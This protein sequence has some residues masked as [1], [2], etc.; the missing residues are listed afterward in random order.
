MDSYKAL[1]EDNP[2]RN[3]LVE[4]KYTEIER[5][6]RI[7]FEKITRISRKK[8]KEES[9]ERV[10]S[11]N[12]TSRRK[13]VESIENE[14]AKMFGRILRQKPFMSFKE[15]DRDFRRTRKI[16]DRISQKGK[17]RL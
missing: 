12:I 16:S 6:N 2:K 15:S 3:Y 17:Y 14:N 5:E 4:S 9:M 7:L 1:F 11:L 10:R 8:R 13:Q